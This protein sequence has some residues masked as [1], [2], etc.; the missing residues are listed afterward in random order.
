MFLAA[1][2]YGYE[3]VG[4]DEIIS[5]TTVMNQRSRNLMEKLGCTAGKKMILTT[6][7][8]RKHTH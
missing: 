2:K 6:P 8:L 4:P 1:L 7:T 3:T 5:F